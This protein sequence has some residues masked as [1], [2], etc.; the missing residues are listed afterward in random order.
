[1]DYFIANSTHIAGKIKRLYGRASE[2]IHPP[3]DVDKFYI[4]E[5]R[6]PFYLI[7]SA[8]VPYKNVQLAVAAFNELKLPLKVVGEGPLR[9]SLQK[10]AGSSIEF[11]GWVDDPRLAK[12]YA[13]CEALIFPGEEDFGIVPLEA[14]ASGRPV[15]AYDKAGVT[16]S[17]VALDERRG[18]GAKP[19]GIFF[20]DAT[21]ASLI[22]AVRRYQA[23]RHLFDPASLRRHAA[24]FSRTVFKTRM[25]Q[26]INARLLERRCSAR[27]DAETV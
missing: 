15:I 20:P 12:L 14:Q 2:V 27:Q 13:E 24:Q 10:Q 3:V 23:I 5:R 7:I 4:S 18:G 26:F 25:E 19:T 16:E 21:P 11:T 22:E 9:R 17:V 8:L 6:E 1:V